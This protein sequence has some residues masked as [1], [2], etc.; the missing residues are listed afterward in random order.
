MKTWTDKQTELLCNLW[1]LNKTSGEIADAFNFTRSKVMGKIYRLQKA[2]VL[3]LKGQD[4]IKSTPYTGTVVKK[5]SQR[6]AVSLLKGLIKLED[7]KSNQCRYPY[8]DPQDDNF[9]FCG[10]PTIK[11]KS[12]C[13]KCYAVVYQPPKKGKK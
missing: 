10:K 2:G 12:F 3:E 11:D 9:A 8:G 4:Y 1:N 6:N 13:E 5:L 7:L